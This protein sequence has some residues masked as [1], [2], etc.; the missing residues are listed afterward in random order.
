[1]LWC[2]LEERCVVVCAT[3]EVCCGACY[4]RFVCYKNVCATRH[5]CGVADKSVPCL[6]PASQ[7]VLIKGH[8]T[9]L[10]SNLISHVCCLLHGLCTCKV[11]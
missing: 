7:V 8:M 5:V 1:M 9:C 6:W 11:I 4:K 10:T 2:V 3:R